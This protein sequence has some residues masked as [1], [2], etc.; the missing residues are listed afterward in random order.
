[1]VFIDTIEGKYSVNMSTKIGNRNYL[2][3]SA[4]GKAL[5]A[6]LSDEEI[7]TILKRADL[8]KINK[9]TIYDKKEFR[10]ELKKVRAV[11]YAVDNEEEELGL[12]CIAGPV[13]DSTNLCVGAISIAGP[14]KRI[15]I[16]FNNLVD[17][18][19]K[20]CLIASKRLGYF[21]I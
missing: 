6:F 17:E 21:K 2:N 20:A 12:K 8:P 19:K 7:D 5:I 14:S 1:M 13:F 10:N 18:V 16:D 11:G 9:N 15:D 3:S 4:S